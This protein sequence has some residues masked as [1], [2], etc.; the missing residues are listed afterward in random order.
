[1][2]QKGFT[3]IDYIDDYIGVGIPNIAHVSYVTLLDLMSDLDLTIS[4]K[5]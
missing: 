4:Q 5:K 2:H 1:M 3:M